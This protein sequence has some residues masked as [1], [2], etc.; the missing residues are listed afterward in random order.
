VSL[1]PAFIHDIRD[2]YHVDFG[3]NPCEIPSNTSCPSNGNTGTVN[4]TIRQGS[5]TVWTF[6]AVRPAASSG[7]PSKG[8]GV[9]LRHVYY[10]GKQVL[11]RAHVPILN[12]HYDRNACGPYRDWQN[13]ETCF[14]CTAGTDVGTTGF[15]I[16]KDEPKT[17]VDDADDAGNFKGVGVYVKGQEVIFVSELTAG[18]YR[19]ISEWTFHTNGTIKPRFKF[20]GVQNQCTCNLHFHHV[21]WRMDFDVDGAHNNRVRECKKTWFW[22]TEKYFDKEAKSFR[23]G[24]KKWRVEN[25]EASC[26][27][28]R[29]GHHDGDGTGDSWAKG[30][31]WVVRYHVNELEDGVGCVYC[32][33]TSATIQDN[34]FLTG[35][36]VDRSDVVIWYRSSFD[37][38]AA[39]SH[40]HLEIVGPDL[41]PIGKFG[42]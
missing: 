37:H 40:D 13:A 25:G 7:H 29:P 20:G 6:Q 2:L 8:S 4:V 21:Y 38:D 39:H 5:T 19:Y 33:G 32:S 16:C 30:D 9:E 1:S 10:R 28:I 12:V 27:E 17:F 18:W 36:N 42:R 41:V 23:N 34:V 3:A 35:E 24:T 22:W 31:V 26:Y 15:R 11:Y 14:D